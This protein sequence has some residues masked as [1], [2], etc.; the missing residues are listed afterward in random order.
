MKELFSEKEVR[1]L[2]N[3]NEGQFLEFKSLW[4]LEK[5]NKKAID[6][7]TVRDWIA[8]YVA[9]FANA[10]GG[11]LILGAD[12]DGKPTGHDYPDDAVQEFLN[13][14]ERRL[15]PSIRTN[16]QQVSIDGQSLIFFQVD[17]HPEAVMVEGNGFP[18]RMN[19]QIVRE[20][21][22]VINERKQ[23]YRRVGYEH[24]V[25]PEANLNDLDL[26]LARSFFS[27]SALADRPIENILTTYGLIH[28]K[29][30]NWA[31]TNAALLLFGKLPINRWHPRSGI[32]FFRVDGKNREFG[33][34]RNVQQLARLELPLASLIPEAY[35]S[36]STYIR[37][38]EKLR[39]LFFKEMPE[40]P[41]FA[42]QE[43]LINA[44][45]HR[46]YNDMGREI[47]VWFF[48]DRMEVSS[49]GDL[50][51][52]VTL[53]RLRRR[54]R[55]H[56]SRNPLIV[57]VLVDAGIM[58][59]EGEGIPRMYE[60]M[61]ES[62]LKHPQFALDG[63]TFFVTL[64]NQPIYEGPGVEWKS[65]VEKLGL[66]TNQKRVLLAHPNG[67]SNEDYRNLTRLDRDHAY[68]EIQELITAGVLVSSGSSGRGATY[69]PSPN[70]MQTRAW[71]EKRIPKLKA[72][73]KVNQELDNTEYRRLF[74]M[75]RSA[76]TRELKRLIEEG[77]LKLVGSKRGSR[78]TPGI[79]LGK[80]LDK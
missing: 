68:R 77:F 30:T 80:S 12:D 33:A 42:W 51:L 28:S 43:A 67:F 65:L 24:R 56:A 41:T 61:E 19:D 72:Y 20:P 38:S 31:V 50:V 70:L 6:R 18:Y 71:L 32:R 69:A 23:A 48:D 9:A 55:I 1:A 53:A 66:P 44:V 73:F 62:F 45:A 10:D 39:N 59:E 46:D 60:E 79:I 35:R 47:E 17:I 76:A 7:R 22:E 63:S 16:A 29:A 21:Q 58:R 3:K 75:T 8:E 36:A 5:N 15:R 74:K 4:D 78:Y 40:Y 37:K 27:K 49:P 14:T 13:V 64:R 2:L 11:I 54:S 26:D 57:R 25:F 34:Q 52:P